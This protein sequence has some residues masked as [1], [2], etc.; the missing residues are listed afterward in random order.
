MGSIW[1]KMGQIWL[2]LR[3]LLRKTYSP[4]VYHTRFPCHMGG[5]MVTFWGSRM[6]VNPVTIATTIITVWSIPSP[7]S[8]PTQIQSHQQNT[9]CIINLSI[10]AGSHYMTLPTANQIAIPL[11]IPNPATRPLIITNSVP[12]L[13]Q[14]HFNKLKMDLTWGWG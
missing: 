2:G 6:G 8:S 12:P 11:T 7:I 1:P 5:I 3:P 14:S 13:A 10:R 4:Q 9:I